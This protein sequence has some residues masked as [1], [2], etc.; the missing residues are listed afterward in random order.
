MLL[1][2]SSPITVVMEQLQIFGSLSFKTTCSVRKTWCPCLRCDGNKAACPDQAGS[3][4]RELQSSVFLPS[5]GWGCES[6][7]ERGLL[8]SRRRF[9]CGEARFLLMGGLVS[10]LNL[11]YFSVEVDY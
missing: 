8:G 3:L 11:N 7:L 1:N 9:P 5:L 6:H 10:H 2:L 4:G